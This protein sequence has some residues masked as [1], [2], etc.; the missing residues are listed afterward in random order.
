MIMRTAGRGR[1][2]EPSTLLTVVC[3]LLFAFVAVASGQDRDDGVIR[4][5]TDLI[6]FE[7][8]VSDQSGRPTRGLRA[9]DFKVVED[10]VER[11]IDFFEPV[12]RQNEKRPLSIVFALDVSGSMT[13]AELAQLQIALTRFTERLA[14]YNSNFAVMTFGM[15]VKTLQGF[16]NKRDKIEKALGKL[17]GDQEGLSTHAYDAVDDAIR[18]LVKKSPP[19]VRDQIPRR[20]VI[21][22]SDGFPVGDTVTAKTVIERANESETSVYAV[23]LP[24]FSRLQGNKKPLLTILEASGLMESTGGRSFYANEK[25]FEPLFKSLEEELTSTYVIAL[26][27]KDGTQKGK[28]NQVRISSRSNLRV[29]QNRSGYLQP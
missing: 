9:E 1:F 13:S 6:A 15:N 19:R 28:F 22:V 8:S 4:V 21:V 25:S 11:P 29:R 26:Y 20:V 27:P 7:V 16:T 18:M 12:R 2:G 14:D 17:A 10:G 23:I 24:S 3:F 5:D